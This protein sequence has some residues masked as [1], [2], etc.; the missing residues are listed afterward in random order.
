MVTFWVLKKVKMYSLQIKL[1]LCASNEI[2]N[3]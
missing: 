3:I 2:I 1:M